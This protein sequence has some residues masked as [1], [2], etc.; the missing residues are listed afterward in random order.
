MDRTLD[1]P[2]PLLN[3]GVSDGIAGQLDVSDN[4]SK[5][6]EQLRSVAGHA[7]RGLSLAVSVGFD[8]QQLSWSAHA[9]CE[10]LILPTKKLSSFSHCHL[11][12]ALGTAEYACVT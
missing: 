5:Q 9:D 10:V 8:A 7:R 11:Q 12:P 2:L 4:R 6:T 1:Y 3:I